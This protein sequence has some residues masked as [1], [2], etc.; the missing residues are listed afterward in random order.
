MAQ[1][2]AQRFKLQLL[3]PEVLVSEAI[4]AAEEWDAA[5]P[6][7]GSLTVSC[8]CLCIVMWC[9]VGPCP[10]PKPRAHAWLVHQLPHSRT[11]SE[12]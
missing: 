4:Q 8:E 1:D 5:H 10:H 3:E 6:P 2:L 9:Y 11:C 12:S 7:G